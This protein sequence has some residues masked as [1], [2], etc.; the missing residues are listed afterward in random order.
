MGDAPSQ[1]L[2]R[3]AAAFL[4]AV[5]VSA[6]IIIYAATPL[7]VAGATVDAAVSGSVY[8][9]SAQ[10]TKRYYFDLERIGGKSAVL[11]AELV[12]WFGSLWQGRRLAWTVAILSS[13][14][15]LLCFLASRLPPLPPEEKSMDNDD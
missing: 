15:S 7:E 10:D 4:L 9:V 2:L 6:S 13:G 11:Q 5:G 1:I 8:V 14:A 3:R 12:D